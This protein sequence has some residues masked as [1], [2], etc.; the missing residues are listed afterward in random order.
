[1][2]KN[3][4]FKFEEMNSK[5][6]ATKAVSS[7]FK[8]AGAEIV[9]VDVAP[10]VKRTSGISYRELSITFADSQVIIFRIK[11]SGDIYQALLNGKV[12]PMKNQDDHVAAITELVKAMESGRTA[13]QAK[14]AKA[15]VKLPNSIKTTVPN[16][17]KLLIEKR[18]ALKEAIAAA[19]QELEQIKTEIAK[20]ARLDSATLDAANDPFTPFDQQAHQAATSPYNRTAM[21]EWDDLISGNYEKGAMAIAGMNILI[22]N[23][24][25]SFRRGQ[26][27][28]GK[29]WEVEMKHHYGYFKD[30]KG[31]DGDELDVFVKNNLEV[32]PDHAYIISQVDRD[33]SFDEHKV[34]IGAQDE[35]EAKAIYLSNYK[36]G[37]DG[38]GSIEKV[39]IDELKGRMYYSE[40]A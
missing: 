8:K 3:I 39:T 31:A 18:D 5:D 37:W 12:R 6:K 15:K 40:A 1:M 24:A 19:E 36:P 17:E 32:E 7:Y 13:F 20:S 9:Q 4:V 30:S 21:P 16:K 27:E 26:G 35:D 38:L 22:E 34:V 33:G 2:S 14:L 28:D 29:K 11:Q 25:G 10:N 23:P